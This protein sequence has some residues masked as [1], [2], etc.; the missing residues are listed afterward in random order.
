MA[1]RD[2]EDD[3]KYFLLKEPWI[4]AKREEDGGYE[5]LPVQSLLKVLR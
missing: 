3:R 1:K 4:E 5:P 2:I